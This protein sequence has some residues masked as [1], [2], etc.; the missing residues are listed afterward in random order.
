M[1]LNNVLAKAQR[2][3][4]DEDWNRQVEIGAAAQRAGSLNGKGG[5]DPSIAAM[6][7][8]AFGTPS[9]A[10]T[11]GYEKNPIPNNVNIRG[12]RINDGTPVQII[13]EQHTPR[14]LSKS[15]LPKAIL[16][17]FENTPS[18]VEAF[19]YETAPSSVLESLNLQETTPNTV[20]T[21]RTVA[22]Q[23]NN[24]GIDYNY[25]KYLIDESIERHLR[26]SVN[27]GLNLSDIKGMRIAQGSIIQFVDTKGN[28]YEGK[29]TLK[30]KAK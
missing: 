23:V 22:P 26:G 19:G 30:K 18:P 14:D 7:Q 12:S 17:S 27:E 13:Q 2:M 11:T 3:M 6:E 20:I 15:K 24:G 28:L 9:V 25:I 29:L 4:L 8:I 16:D 10:P 1:N 21:E 5:Y